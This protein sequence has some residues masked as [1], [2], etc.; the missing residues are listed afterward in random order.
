MYQSADRFVQEFINAI[1]F[2]TIHT[3]QTKYQAA[4][5]LLIDDIQFYGT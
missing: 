1:R 4:D 3:F 2:D 5:I